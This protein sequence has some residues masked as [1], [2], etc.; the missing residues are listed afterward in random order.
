MDPFASLIGQDRA[1]ELLAASYRQGRLASA[2]LL[3]GPQGVGRARAAEAFSALLLG[4]EEAAARERAL[5]QVRAGTHPD[6]LWIAPET[7]RGQPSIGIERA[8]A[9]TEFASRP[10]L[11]APRSV[12]VID[13]A[14]A[15]TEAAAN[16]LLKTWEEPG[17][18]IP[19]AIAPSQYAL[20]PT[21][22]SRCQC[23]PFSRLSESDVA[24]VLE[25][26]GH[27]GVLAQPEVMASAQGRPGAALRASACLQALPAG[28]LADLRAVPQAGLKQRDAAAR[29]A[30]ERELLQLAAEAASQLEAETQLW[31]LDALQSSYWQQYLQGQLPHCPLP[32][33]VQGRHALQAYAQPRLAW[34]VLL[35]QFGGVLPLQSRV[36]PSA[37]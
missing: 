33:L 34:E 18:T 16:A 9:L 37:A 32:A 30:F 36:F 31:L 20:L 8:R 1:I 29:A 19:I 15:L 21:L 26:Q 2:Y 5:R 14:E 12:A 11:Q 23:I 10:P 22:A 25:Q 24:R 7:G 28:L 4:G 13:G 27:H 35:L 6:C 3:A 17:R